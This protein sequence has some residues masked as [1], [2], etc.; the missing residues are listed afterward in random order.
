VAL[1]DRRLDAAGFQGEAEF[2]GKFEGECEAMAALRHEERRTPSPAPTA[3]P[4]R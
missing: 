3:E 1:Y 2:L 4:E